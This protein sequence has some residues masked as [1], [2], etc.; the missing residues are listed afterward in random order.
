M[1]GRDAT[2]RI[3]D[4]AA[5]AICSSRPVIGIV[6]TYMPDEEV[7]RMKDRYASAVIAAG[8]APLIIPFTSDVSVYEALLPR[9]DGF[10]LSGGQDINPV[11]YGGD[12]AYGK[13]S[14]LTPEREEVE[15]L[16]LSYAYQ[17]D[18]PLLGICRGMQMLNVFFGGSLYLDLEEQ[19]G[20]AAAAD[21]V[22]RAGEE[23]ATRAGCRVNHW[24][25]IDYAT[26]T[27]TVTIV[28]PS[29]L[30]GILRCEHACV[31]SMHHQ[32][33]KIVPAGLSVAA[34]GPDGLVEAVEVDDC[35]FMMGVQWHPEYFAGPLGSMAPLFRAL[36][37]HADMMRMRDGRCAD[38]LR[39]RKGDD[40]AL[41][42]EV[43]F[44]DY[45]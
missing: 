21:D 13:L 27:H 26:P 10:I 18:M 1:T 35:T 12:I 24:Q 20:G 22:P 3:E 23:P 32:G 4:I 9:M 45:I 29:K 44:A 17:F 19:F 14:E 41:W 30:G 28:R 31:N 43:R 33:V 38:C 25:T 2:V 8:G 40:D 39:I 37:G 15:Y 36:V 7:L 11:R 16:I 34:T 5:K 6:P 42:P